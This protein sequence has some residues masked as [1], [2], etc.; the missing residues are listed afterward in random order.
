MWFRLG[1]VIFIQDTASKIEGK[2][3]LMYAFKSFAGG[4]GVGIAALILNFSRR[5]KCATRFTTWPLYV[6]GTDLGTYILER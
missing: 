5:W 3:V 1:S 6:R 4:G 2:L